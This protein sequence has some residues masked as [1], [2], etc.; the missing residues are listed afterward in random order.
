MSFACDFD[1]HPYSKGSCMQE[2]GAIEQN[3]YSVHFIRD[4]CG[5]AAQNFILDIEQRALVLPGLYLVRPVDAFDGAYEGRMTSAG[6]NSIRVQIPKGV[7]GSGWN[8]EIDR[9]YTLKKHVYF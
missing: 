3:G 1:L 9:T 6:A 2:L 7:E 5:G 4:G 8:K